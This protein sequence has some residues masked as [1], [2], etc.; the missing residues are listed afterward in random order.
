SGDQTAKVWEAITGKVLWTFPAPDGLTGV[1]FNPDGSQLAVGSL[2]GTARIFLLRIED[3]MALAKQRLTRTLTIEECQQ[4]LH[5]EE[6]PVE[7]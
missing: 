2:D 3:L 7:P 4:Y 1:A 5:V 6:C